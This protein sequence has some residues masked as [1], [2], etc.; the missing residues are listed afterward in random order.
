MADYKKDDKTVQKVAKGNLVKKK[1]SVI[2]SVA[3]MFIPVDEGD[4]YNDIVGDIII[5]SIIDTFL[6]SL[7]ALL[8]GSST[9]SR[10]NSPK[11]SY[12]DYYDRSNPKSND[13]R[14][15]QPRKA[16]DYDIV[17]LDSRREAELVLSAL[18][19]LIDRYGKASVADYYDL[20]G[21][22]ITS[23]DY[24]STRYGWE[25]LSGVRIIIFDGGYSLKLPRAYP[26]Y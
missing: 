23:S 18:E 12:R 22:D 26:V 1:K 16:L 10:R 5:P 20:A 15:E 7:T 8:K 25:D 17:K 14:R 6:D 2:K 3:G 9:P 19:D 24:P 13:I 21:I 11:V 4:I